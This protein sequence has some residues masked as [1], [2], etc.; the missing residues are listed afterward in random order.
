MHTVARRCSSVGYSTVFSHLT[1]CPGRH[2][3]Q[4]TAASSLRQRDLRSRA[5]QNRN[6]CSSRHLGRHPGGRPGG[7]RIGQADPPGLTFSVSVSASAA[8]RSSRS[9]TD[10]PV[11]FTQ[12]ARA[13]ARAEAHWH[14]ASLAGKGR[15]GASVKTRT[16]A[17]YAT[18]EFVL[19][20]RRRLP[21][22]GRGQ[23]APRPRRSR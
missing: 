2:A 5:V 11:E 16:S 15:G 9:L 23:I 8:P 21:A 14:H 12:Y 4:D 3:A 7:S 6:G 17:R 10:R 13:P 22:C 19:S 1:R 20:R 18:C